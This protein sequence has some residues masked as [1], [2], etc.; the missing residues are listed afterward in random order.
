MEAKH[1]INTLLFI[2]TL[3]I[4]SCS[5]RNLQLKQVN[6]D[7][8]KSSI[9]STKQNLDK[10]ARV[11]SQAVAND[12]DLRTFIKEKALDQ[13]DND[14]DIIYNFVK[15]E[16]IGN[17]KTFRSELL[18][19]ANRND[20]FTNIEKNLPLVTIYIPKLPSGFS[21]DKWDPI[22]QIPYVTS[23][24]RGGQNKMVFYK[25]GGDS[26]S[27][28]L[29]K[30]P[31][32][33]TLV[34]KNNERIIL[35]SNKLSNAA[36]VSY[37]KNDFQFIDKTFDKH[38]ASNAIQSPV[39]SI[40]NVSSYSIVDNN[41][42]ITGVPSTVSKSAIMKEV[43]NLINNTKSSVSGRRTATPFIVDTDTIILKNDPKLMNAYNIMGTNGYNWQ[44][45]NIYYGLTPT[46]TVGT[47][48]NSIYE[49]IYAL[50][51]SVDALNKMSDQSGDPMLVDN[52][53]P[54]HG[55]TPPQN[56]FWTDGKFEFQID[57]LINDVT[58]NGASI[59][60]Y[61]S[62]A[63]EDIYTVVYITLPG[64]VPTYIIWGIMPKHYY[65]AQ[66][67]A[68]IPLLPW[69]LENR[70]FSWKFNF[71]ETDEQQTVTNTETITGQFATNFEFNATWGT[72]TKVGLKFGASATTTHTQTYTIVTTLGSDALGDVEANF[73]EP[74]I[75]ARDT[76]KYYLGAVGAPKVYVSQLPYTYYEAKNPYVSLVLLPQKQY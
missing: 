67:D 70:S 21:A 20:S 31:G 45:D 3:L 2:F 33:P 26:L 34:V 37:N 50:R 39:T 4:F 71:S 38:V 18:K 61:L 52:I 64:P 53:P 24:T 68:A 40:D 43:S 59:T 46:N 66:H 27:L 47:I 7:A 74:V 51:F 48:D 73:G 28:S 55:T 49:N 8:L 29:D 36:F 6:N 72:N 69:N 65:P 58:G 32:F 17:G 11:L 10:F 13:S 63:P 9:Q 22:D 19:Y 1:F 16:P 15:D 62:I 54:G 44:R 57:I 5:K 76:S 42:A 30:I 35:K 41:I 23:Y 12:K 60:K 14:Y 75:C 56:I 25:N